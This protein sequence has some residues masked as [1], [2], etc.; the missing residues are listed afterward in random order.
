MSKEE[1][2]YIRCGVAL[3]LQGCSQEDV[4]EHP[5][6]EW[7]VMTDEERSD[8]LDDYLI[9]HRNDHVDSW[10]SAEDKDGNDISGDL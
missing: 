3:D 9:D 4:Y 10:R 1:M 6:A 8:L 7:D 5:K 2:I